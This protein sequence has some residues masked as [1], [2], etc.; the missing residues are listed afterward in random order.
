[1][2]RPRMLPKG[3]DFIDPDMME[4]ACPVREFAELRKTAP[5]WWNVPGEGKGG[6]FHDGGY[7]VVTKHEHFEAISMHNDDLSTSRTV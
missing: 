6:G 2:R 5:V 4:Q 7:W 3:F 1:M